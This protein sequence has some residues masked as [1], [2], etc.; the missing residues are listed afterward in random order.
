MDKIYVY[1]LESESTGQHYVG[2]SKY[3]PKRLRQHNRGQ[4]AGTRGKGP[5]KIVHQEKFP[6]YSSAR[7]RE[8]FLKSRKGRNWLRPGIGK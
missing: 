1:V 8:K 2:I 4:S 7:E 6:D 5:W 3:G